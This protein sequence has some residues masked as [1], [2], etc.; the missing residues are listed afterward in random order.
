MQ[1]LRFIAEDAATALAQIQAQLGPNAV[2]VSVKPLPAEGWMGLLGGKRRIEVIAGV[3]E[4]AAET[5][6]VGGA[7]PCAPSWGRSDFGADG[8]TR[9]TL[10]NT[11][12]PASGSRWPAITRLEEC[13]LL[14]VYA[15][16][17][18]AQLRELHGPLAPDSA[19]REWSL[20]RGA[21]TAQ[22]R[23][24]PALDEGGLPRPHVFIGPP[25]SGKTTILCK[26]LTLAVLT[27]AKSAQVW[28]LD[29]H[30][31]NTAEFLT[32]HCEMLG[33]PLERFWSAT[34]GPADLLFVDLPGV[35]AGDSMALTSLA[36][37]IAGMP[38]PRVHLVLNAAYETTTLLNQWRAFAV[39][40]PEDIILTHA[41]ETASLV[42]MWNLVFGT[43]C[44]VRF[45]SGGQKVPGDFRHATP[46]IFLPL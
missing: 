31:A 29:G 19:E 40:Q 13:G 1:L 15:D 30:S 9:P 39:F 22:W 44:T 42:K 6:A 36:G 14:P 7:T 11:G 43:N 3:Q 4:T 34:P 33:V 5:A 25:G 28:R 24:A 12:R 10:P 46:E 8:V 32:I 41:D 35:E 21:L 37:Q 23:P 27:E 16:R 45:L 17:L 26:W 2:V 18:Q 20:V 38:A